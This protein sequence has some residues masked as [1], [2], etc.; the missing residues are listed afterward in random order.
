MIDVMMT[1]G[2]ALLLVLSITLLL[3]PSETTALPPLQSLLPAAIRKNKEYTP[4]LFFKVPPGLMPECD[5][6]E[7]TVRE[8]EK[9]LGVRVERMDILRKPENE[10]LLALL[11][12]QRTPP[13]LYHRESCQTVYLTPTKGS[14]SAGKKVYVNKDRVRAWAKGRYLTH[15]S[16]AA[17]MPDNNKVAPP[18]LLPSQE[19]GAVDQSE[20]LEEMALTP[21]QRQGKGLIEERTKPAKKEAS[22][23]K[24]G[25]SK[26][27]E[28]PM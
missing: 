7:K 27:V 3:M 8:I 18:T 15:H 2:V 22:A 24:S 1:R 26:M 17:V 9:E 10:A 25:T 16:A 19:R 14:S 13:L 20:L 4:L 21:E 28:S 5:A 23:P 12:Q 6:M 11:A